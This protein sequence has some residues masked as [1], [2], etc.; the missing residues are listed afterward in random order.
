MN[1]AKQREKNLRPVERILRPGLCSELD[2]RIVHFGIKN[3]QDTNRPFGNF[4]QD[5]LWG[6]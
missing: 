6:V 1:F 5:S 4:G 3:R 2:I